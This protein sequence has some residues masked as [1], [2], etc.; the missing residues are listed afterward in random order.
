LFG[1]VY[2][3]QYNAWCMNASVNFPVIIRERV[4]PDLLNSSLEIFGSM[5]KVVVDIERGVLALGGELHADGEALL[6]DDGS[7]QMNL[8]GANVY[9]QKPIE[10]RIDYTSLINIRPAQGNTE[11]LIQDPEVCA[12]VSAVIKQLI[13]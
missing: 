5:V 1:S 12:Q 2:A 10:D 8:W 7:S 4:A 13:L 11:M 6:L 9:P 3:K